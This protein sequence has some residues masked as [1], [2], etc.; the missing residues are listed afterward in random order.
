[1]VEAYPQADRGSPAVL[2]HVPGTERPQRDGL[3]HGEA[4]RLVEGR[5]LRDHERSLRPVGIAA[6]TGRCG[7]ADP[8][9]AGRAREAYQLHLAGPRRQDA[10]VPQPRAAG[11]GGRAALDRSG[12]AA[13]SPWRS[14][15]PTSE[16]KSLMRISYAVLCLNK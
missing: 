3:L 16:L 2:G 10:L 13:V 4:G 9:H 5:P 1:M 8:A 11:S 7:K 6:A 15:E 14:E 12:Q